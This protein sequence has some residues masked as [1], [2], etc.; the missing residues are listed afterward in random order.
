MEYRFP[1]EAPT[2]TIQILKET[3]SSVHSILRNDLTGI[4]LYGSLAM[5]CFQPKSSDIDLILVIK[6]E[7]PEEKSKRVLQYLKGTC[8]KERRIELSLVTMHALQDPRYPMMVDL[9][10]EHWGNTFE[11]QEDNEILSN[12]YTTKERGFRVWG[13]PIDHVFKMIPIQ[14]H[15]RSVIEDLQHTRKYLREKPEHA[16]YDIA[17]YWILGSCR[18]LAL[19]KEDRVLSKLEGGQW[20][21]TNLP[22]RYHQLI[23]LALSYYQGGKNE[24]DRWNDEKLDAFASY[25]TSV[26]LRESRLKMGA[27]SEAQRRQS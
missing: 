27:T 13:E 23:K 26:I 17:T 7:L 6:Q 24:Y 14:Y 1:K 2:S 15:V 21:L 25:M 5:G 9:H 8:S 11:K 10:Y 20:G 12:L 18:I 19:I 22:K 16:G 3:L 4:Y